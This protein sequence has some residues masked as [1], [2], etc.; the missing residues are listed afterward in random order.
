M[1][2]EELL[3]RGVEREAAGDFDGAEAVYRE[4]DELG[5]ADGAILLGQLLRRRGDRSS[6][7]DALRRAE[8]RG[9]PEAGSCLGNLL[10]DSGDIEG[11]KA[12]YER[13]IAAGSTDAVLNLGLTLAQ[14]G[15]LDQALRHLRRAEETDPAVASWAIGKILEGREDLDGA[16]A[17]YGRGA[18]AGNAHAAFGLGLIRESQGDRE[19]ARVAMQR[20]QDLGHENAEKALE[21]MDTEA[22]ARASVDSA[23][24][25]APLYVAACGEVLSAVNACLEVANRAIGAR[26]KAAERPQHEISIAHFLQYADEAEREFG[27]VYRAFEEACTAARETAANLVA[28]NPMGADLVLA[29]SVGDDQQVLDNVATVKGILGANYGPTTYAFMQGVEAANALIQNPPDEGNIY[30]P[31]ASAQTDERAC[32]WCAETIKAAAVICRF[33]GRDVKVHANPV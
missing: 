29:I 27:P 5:D 12:A 6:A 21:A 9:H 1:I 24:K 28:A 22:D 20:A 15:E 32:P 31:L 2:V 7:A 10:S 23:L 3:T 17:A 26:N 25:W 19:G 33:C 11:A 4:A 8:E 13:S 30:R 14:E 18:D 16:A